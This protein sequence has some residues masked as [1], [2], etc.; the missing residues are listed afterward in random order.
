MIKSIGNLKN[1][2]ADVDLST[3][4]ARYNRKNIN[5]SIIFDC[6]YPS[7]SRGYPTTTKGL[8]EIQ[9]SFGSFLLTY[10][11]T[12]RTFKASM[13]SN[14]T[15]KTQL[16]WKVV[17]DGRGIGA[18]P[19]GAEKNAVSKG[20]LQNFIRTYAQPY[21][22]G[23]ELKQML[24]GKVDVSEYNGYAKNFGRTEL[25]RD[26]L[27]I[28]ASGINVVGSNAVFAGDL[29]GGRAGLRL[30]STRWIGG[31]P[32]IASNS[33]QVPGLYDAY[34]SMTFSFLNSQKVCILSGN[35]PTDYSQQWGVTG[36]R[37]LVCRADVRWKL[38]YN[39]RGGLKSINYPPQAR[40]VI[41]QMYADVGGRVWRNPD[42]GVMGRE[43]R[44]VE[45]APLHFI[46]GVY[47]RVVQDAAWV[48]HEGDARIWLAPIGV[49]LFDK[50]G[51]LYYG[52]NVRRD[53]TGLAG[54]G[55]HYSMIRRLWWR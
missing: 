36:D 35:R 16:D 30:Q 37:R 42:N 11:T 45:F 54:A 29:P 41:V 28:N 31:E 27:N 8:L 26:G 20:N 25:G 38:F 18:L 9:N 15:L 47:G 33:F 39:G 14:N 19:F 55:D 46:R 43:Y 40:E 32:S 5:D 13:K 7:L 44:Y 4:A 53:M 50:I 17:P 49:G 23:E 10:Y 3:L 22:K 34:G 6:K 1:M 21:T 12:D 52:P 24:A 48:V 2:P 51:R